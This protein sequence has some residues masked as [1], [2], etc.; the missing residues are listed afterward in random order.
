MNLFDEIEKAMF[1]T[2][3]VEPTHFSGMG[4]C[5]YRFDA[6]IKQQQCCKA[7]GIINKL[8]PGST[9]ARHQ[10]RMFIKLNKLRAV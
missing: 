5:Y 7:I 4:G 1:V 2:R 3:D 10:S 9:K 8:K 6:L